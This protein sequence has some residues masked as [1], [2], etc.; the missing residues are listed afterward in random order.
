VR[1]VFVDTSGF[2]ALIDGAD[3]HH[4]SADD[5]FARAHREKWRLVT[6]NAVVFETHALLLNRLRPG[7]EIALAF[8]D[9]ISTDRYQVVRAQR[10]DEQ[11]ATAIIRAHRDKSYS[12]CDALSFA[13]MERH[14]IRE[15]ISFDQDFR[16]Y[17]RFA[18]L[19]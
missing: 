5:L 18:L 4:E 17:G 10:S 11:K 14:R 2:Y 12:L 1:R 15:A 8:L 6:S 16:S 13:V 7:R 9:S 3:R 19:S